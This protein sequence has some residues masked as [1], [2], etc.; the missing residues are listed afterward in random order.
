MRQLKKK[1]ITVAVVLLFTAFGGLSFAE[2]LQVTGVVKT[3]SEGKIVVAD[4]EGNEVTFTLGEDTELA[5][6]V[7]AGSSVTIEAEDGKAL[8]VDAIEE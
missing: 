8:F 3:L 2:S 6:N 5:E 7:K 4:E 1:I